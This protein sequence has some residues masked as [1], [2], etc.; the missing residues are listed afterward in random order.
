MITSRQ[1]YFP[2]ETLGQCSVL[3]FCTQ[4][5]TII[6]IIVNAIIIVVIVVVVVI[7]NIFYILDHGHTLSMLT[8]R[9]TY[10]DSK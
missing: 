2:N 7:C 3:A 6:F 5:V 1:S 10:Q 8:N 9:L 4:I